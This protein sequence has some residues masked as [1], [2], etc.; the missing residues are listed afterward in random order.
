M[1]VSEILQGPVTEE[2]VASRLKNFDWKY[3][4][5]EDIR[6]QQRG[7][8]AMLQLESQ[9]YEFWKQNPERA[10]T[11]WTKHSPYGKEGVTPSFIL[12]LES[13]GK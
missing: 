12:R 13:Q 2:I 4:F 5:A 9:V 8:Q 10:I 3:E 6:R 11:L 1:K 7:H